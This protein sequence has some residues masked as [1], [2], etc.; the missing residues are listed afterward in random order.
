LKP[1]PASNKATEVA[2]KWAEAWVKHDG[3]SAQDW[4]N[5]LRPY[6]TDEYLPTF[7]TT[8]P[9]TVPSS[10]VTG[11]PSTK[12]SLPGS[13]TVLV[14]TDKVKLSL[15]VIEIAPGVWRVSEQNEEA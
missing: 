4:V 1:V 14:P 6:T 8:D 7:S 11:P 10:K 2:V 13:A 15:V 3:V 9:Q 12:N 5:G